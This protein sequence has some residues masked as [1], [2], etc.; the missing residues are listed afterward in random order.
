MGGR[1][2]KTWILD[3]Q[4]ECNKNMHA[5]HYS[6]QDEDSSEEEEEGEEKEKEASE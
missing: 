3:K 2:S 4:I 6:P 5:L 1:Q